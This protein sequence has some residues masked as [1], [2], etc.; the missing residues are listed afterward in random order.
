VLSQKFNHPAL[1]SGLTP[2]LSSPL[3]LPVQPP[4]GDQDYTNIDVIFMVISLRIFR[5]VCRR[6]NEG[7]S[8]L[9]SVRLHDQEAVSVGVA[10]EELRRHGIVHGG[11]N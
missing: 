11:L 4:F 7:V 1:S 6:G 8:A 9:G 10:E 2:F 3:Q 5:R